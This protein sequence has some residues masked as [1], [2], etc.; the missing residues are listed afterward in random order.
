M[1]HEDHFRFSS[2]STVLLGTAVALTFC[3]FLL[4][5]RSH[6]DPS[7]GGASQQLDTSAWG[8]VAYGCALA[9]HVRKNHAD[10]NSWGSLGDDPGHGSSLAAG[11]LFFGIQTAHP[12]SPF[13]QVGNSIIKNSQRMALDEL[14][15]ALGHSL[16]LCAE[17]Q[18]AGQSSQELQ[19]DTSLAGQIT[20]GCALAQR[21]RTNHPKE[22]SW[23]G[24]DEDPGYESVPAVGYL[25]HAIQMSDG[26]QS[27]SG[28]GNRL[29]R[30][31]QRFKLSNLSKALD[32]TLT[33][34]RDRQ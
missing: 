19:P 3:L 13:V 5:L 26:E 31:M 17:Q 27:F 21:V 2:G 18:P 34:C 1:M 30:D 28:L 8:R 20:Y 6:A 16:D 29:I 10:R 12:K 25:F 24:L 15:N 23:A 7:T 4:P 33:R 11:Y 22:K 32:T 14:G 9:R